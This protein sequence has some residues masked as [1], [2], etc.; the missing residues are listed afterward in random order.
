M[1]LDDQEGKFIFSIPCI[2][3][4]VAKFRNNRIT[5]VPVLYLKLDVFG[6]LLCQLVDS[7]LRFF[8]SCVIC[9]NLAA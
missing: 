6:G 3:F 2:P 4:M 9:S 5:D 1:E 7:S 8:I